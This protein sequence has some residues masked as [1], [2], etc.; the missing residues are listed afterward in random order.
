ME[1]ERNSRIAIRVFIGV[2]IRVYDWMLLYSR[3]L[4]SSTDESGLGGSSGEPK[5]SRRLLDGSI[6]GDGDSTPVGHSKE[7]IYSL[8]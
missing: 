3:F 4:S 7:R 2:G 5:R 8:P 1:R 6:P